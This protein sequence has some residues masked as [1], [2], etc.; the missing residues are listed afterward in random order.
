MMSIVNAPTVV[1]EIKKIT[2]SDT[3]AV[4]GLNGV[5]GR[6]FILLMRQSCLH[7]SEKRFDDPTVE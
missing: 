1:P 3:T 5:T 6:G 4:C 2:V 7:L